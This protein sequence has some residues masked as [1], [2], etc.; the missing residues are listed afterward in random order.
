[1]FPLT[2]AFQFKPELKSCELMLDPL[3]RG[4]P[5][6]DLPT[7]SIRT[8]RL[9]GDCRFHRKESM[10]SLRHLPI[11][12]VTGQYFDQEGLD[13]CFPEDHL[14]SFVY[15]QG[16]RRGFEIRN[17]HLETLVA[18]PGSRLR[19]LV[20]LGCS[21]LTSSVI[22]S[23]LQ[24]LPTLEYFAVSIVTVNVLHSNSVLT[25]PLAISVLKIQIT[26]AWYAIP[27]IAK[28]QKICN[29]LETGIMRRRPPPDAMYLS[30]HNEVINEDGRAERWKTIAEEANFTLK[31]AL[32][33]IKKMDKQTGKSC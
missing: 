27:L 23:C 10:P 25:L 15:A 8:L 19:K 4:I 20:L 24:Y 3:T 33:K 31:L 22:T 6:A 13:E 29:A 30:M 26:H 12:G 7:N 21:R 16:H 14:D 32:G 5:F 2:E 18:G 9:S 17:R 1:M 28:E 11:N